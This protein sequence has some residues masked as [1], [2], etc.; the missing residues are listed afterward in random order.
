M[1]VYTYSEAR[2]KLAAQLTDYLKQ[3]GDP[4]ETAAEVEFDE[5]PYI[6]GVPKWPGEDAI[7]QY[8]R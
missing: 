3:T 1:Q 7:E 5:Y 2:Q 4:R 6:G 8:E